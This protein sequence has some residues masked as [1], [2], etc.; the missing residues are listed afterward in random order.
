MA[1]MVSVDVRT[2]AVLGLVLRRPASP[3][4]GG[5]LESPGRSDRLAPAASGEVSLSGRLW[6]CWLLGEVD[7]GSGVA[8]ARTGFRTL[9]GSN[10]DRE[11]DSDGGKQERDDE[12]ERSMVFTQQA[13]PPSR[14]LYLPALRALRS[15]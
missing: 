4:A 10:A 12:A 15:H 11:V 5:L 6:L 14:V 8:R 1:L 7:T 9:T 13:E 3:T 2:T